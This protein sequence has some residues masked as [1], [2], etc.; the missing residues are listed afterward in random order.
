MGFVVN[1]N[2]ERSHEIVRQGLSVLKRLAHRGAVGADPKTGDGAGI[3]IQIPHELYNISRPGAYG[4]GLVFLPKAERLRNIC[5]DV[6]AKVV[7]QEGQVLLGW[8]KVPVDD[9]EIGKT[10]RET[11]PVI[12]QVF[13]GKGKRVNSQLE[14]ERKLY[15]IRRKIE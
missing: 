5:K 12:E 1:I 15:A 10:A 13:I 4:T 7:K 14:L 9:S 8:R 3:L 2:G 11:Q 6:F